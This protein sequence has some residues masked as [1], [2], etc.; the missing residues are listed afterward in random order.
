MR[1]WGQIKTSR[2]QYLKIFRVCRI[3]AFSVLLD[4]VLSWVVL[5][6]PGSPWDTPGGAAQGLF[7]TNCLMWAETGC[8]AKITRLSLVLSDGG[9]PCGGWCL[10]T[11]RLAW[12][13]GPQY[14]CNSEYPRSSLPEQRTLML[15]P[16]CSPSSHL[17]ITY[18]S[19]AGEAVQH[20]LTHSDHLK[21]Q[22]C[23]Q[24][25][26]FPDGLWTPVQEI[27]IHCSSRQVHVP[28]RWMV[29]SP[30]PSSPVPHRATVEVTGSANLK[31]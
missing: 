12:S 4:P 1:A 18:P 5:G 15:T 29:S 3:L 30:L 2:K 27:Y 25:A 17:P 26:S 13:Q 24:T 6:I 9:K 16:A 19:F 10:K 23:A 20:C 14:W 11:R 28:A 7:L 22:A 31:C 21:D 8:L